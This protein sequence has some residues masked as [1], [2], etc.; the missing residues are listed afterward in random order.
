[1]WN[2]LLKASAT[3]AHKLSTDKIKSVLVPATF[4][5]LQKEV[6]KVCP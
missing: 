5:W 6:T 1:M 2:V 3:F 4:K